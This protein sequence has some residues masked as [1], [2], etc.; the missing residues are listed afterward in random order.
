[1]SSYEKIQIR[2]LNQFDFY[3]TDTPHIGRANQR[4]FARCVANLPHKIVRH[5]AAD[6]VKQYHS[7]TA[8]RAS[9]AANIALRKKTKALQKVMRLNPLTE[10]SALYN[11]DTQSA[12]AVTMSLHCI[13]LCKRAKIKNFGY[14]AQAI[15]AYKLIKPVLHSFQIK[16]P[17][18]E[19]STN[20]EQYE[21]LLVRAI[22]ADWWMRKI[23][24]IAA[25]TVEHV[26]I[27]AGYVRD[28]R[29]EYASNYAVGLYN[30]N[31]RKNNDFINSMDVENI[32]TGER[33]AL[34]TIFNKTTS[35]PELRR[36]ELMTRIRGMEELADKNEYSS[37]FVT[38]T[39]PSKY[40][41]NSKKFINCAPLDTHKY[42]SNQWQKARAELA[43]QSIDYYGARVVEPHADATPHWHLLLFVKRTQQSALCNVLR[44]YALEHDSNERGA[45]K[46]RIKFEF[47][48]KSKGSAAAY[49]AKYIA[50][51]IDAKNIENE[52]DFNSHDKTVSE[53]IERV[54]A[55]NRLWSMRQFQF[56]GSASVSVYRELRRLKEP[57]RF[58]LAETIRQCADSGDWSAFSEQCRAINVKLWF[59]HTIN[60]YGEPDKKIKGII[61]NDY[62]ILTRPDEYKITR[63]SE[64]ARGDRRATWTCVNNCTDTKTKQVSVAQI[65]QIK[66]ELLQKMPY[67]TSDLLDSIARNVAHKQN[68]LI[69]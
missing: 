43:R 1:M 14:H 28:G 67:L 11:E 7:K 52:P 59:E 65:E 49:I 16:I 39:A 48:N 10:L 35:N 25:R 47:I 5:L 50:K 60:G 45:Q 57:L 36:L 54:T 64:T 30:Y 40:H 51:N 44:L 41:A 22:D 27:V 32:E 15:A 34:E 62:E 66:R 17:V 23:K 13:D 46:N 12:V 24:K 31:Q 55:Y 61:V 3:I 58:E 20:F 53:S 4:F 6:Y 26:Y 68:E 18:N 19:K 63:K 42:L 8:L 56:F 21:R 33:I 69:T 38:I 37:V 29:E 9:R 2:L